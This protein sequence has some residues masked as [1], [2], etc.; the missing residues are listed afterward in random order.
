MYSVPVSL[1]TW[2][3]VVFTDDGVNRNL[4]IDGALDTAQSPQASPTNLYL[5]RNAAIGG[6]ESGA[7]PFNGNVSNCQI[8]NIALDGTQVETLYNNGTPLTTATQSANLKGWWKLDNGDIWDNV[9]EQWRIKNNEIT[10]VNYNRG[11]QSSFGFLTSYFNYLTTNNLTQSR[12]ISLWIKYDIN[13]QN[14]TPRTGFFNN[15]SLNFSGTGFRELNQ[16]SSGI[17]TFYVDGINLSDGGWHH[18]ILHTQGDSTA[19]D[20]IAYIDGQLATR[21]VIGTNSFTFPNPGIGYSNR[22]GNLPPAGYSFSNVVMY[23]GDA[24]SNVNTLYNNGTPPDD[25]SSTNPDVWWKVNS[26]SASVTTLEDFS[27]N[28]NDGVSTHTGLLI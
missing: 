18:I 3:H 14:S 1:G 13:R 15:P 19:T 27:G 28:N 5:L 9:A 2:Y 24:T 10:T 12:T 21:S 20:N 23:N 4:Y 17:I 22:G 25:I 16:V 7:Y 26:A 6:T 11:G 8:W